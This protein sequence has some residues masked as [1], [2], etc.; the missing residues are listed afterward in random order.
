MYSVRVVRLKVGGR[1]AKV[2]LGLAGVWTLLA[3]IAFAGGI[4]GMIQRYLLR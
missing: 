4:V 2:A 1:M 3:G